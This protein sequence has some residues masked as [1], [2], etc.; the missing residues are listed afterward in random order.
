[1]AESE[2]ELKSLLRKVKEDSEKAHLKLNIENTKIMASSPIT[3]WQIDG[4]TIETVRD[5][6]FLGS[7]I[8]ADG[9]SSHEIKR[10]LVLERK[11][12]TNL[13]SMLKSRDITLSTKVRLVKAMVF[14]V[15][16][17][18]CESWTIK[19][20]EHR[21]TDAFEMWC[22]RR[23][24]RVPWT[25]R[26][27]S[28]SILK[29]ISPGCSLEGLMLKLKLQ[30]FGHLVQRADSFEKTLMLGKIEGRRRRG[31][32]KMKWLDGI[33]DSMDMSLSELRELVMDRE[34]WCAAIHGVAK[35]RTLLSD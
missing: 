33:T 14:P 24:L 12:M 6:I 4:E 16:M 11:A 22:W 26:R 7:K 2:E 27:S 28:Q 13:D 20:I 29:E 15:V 25:T 18:G 23:L 17:Y 34:A 19:K 10:C 3:S 35:S 31:Q 5:F 32:Q 8:T 21:K 1:M 9:D 30:Y